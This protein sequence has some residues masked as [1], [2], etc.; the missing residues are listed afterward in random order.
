VKGVDDVQSQRAAVEQPLSRHLGGI[1][2]WLKPLQKVC[3]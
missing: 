1:K 3:N 2:V